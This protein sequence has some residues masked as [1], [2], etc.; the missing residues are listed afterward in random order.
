MPFASVT[1]TC[2]SPVVSEVTRK[3]TRARRSWETPAT[4]LKRMSPRLT[5]S[6]TPESAVPPAM[7][8]T[9]GAASKRATWP[10]CRIWK[11]RDHSEFSL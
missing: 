9:P 11:V 10:S 7:A 5:A 1:I 4:L 3:A 6:A 8:R 2:A